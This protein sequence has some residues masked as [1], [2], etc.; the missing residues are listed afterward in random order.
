LRLQLGGETIT[1]LTTSQEIQKAKLLLAAERSAEA[2]IML[3]RAFGNR[4]QVELAERITLVCLYA[5]ALEEDALEEQA[6]NVL[7]VA[8]NEFK[9]KNAL[10]TIYSAASELYAHRGQT[11]AAINALRGEL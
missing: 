2:V 3:R 8:A 11:T 6:L 10:K 9:D 4:N 7:R 1:A 5:R